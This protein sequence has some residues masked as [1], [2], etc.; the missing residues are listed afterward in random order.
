M[1]STRG[2]GFSWLVALTLFA[3]AFFPQTARSA[4]GDVK[5][6]PRWLVIGD[7]YTSGEGIPGTTQ[8]K[9]NT[10]RDCARATGMLTAGIKSDAKA[11]PIV[12]F[13]TV[14]SAR[15]DLALGPPDFVACTGAITDDFQ[16]QLNEAKAG[17]RLTYSERRPDQITSVL[18][19]LAHSEPRWDLVTMS[20]GG[21]NIGFEAIAKGCID[22]V[23]SALPGSIYWNNAW[24]G[25][26]DQPLEELKNR[27]DILVGRTPGQLKAGARTLWSTNGDPGLYNEIADVVRPGGHVIV[28]GYPH[29]LEDPYRLTADGLNSW[30]KS[31]I[32]RQA[33]N[34]QG[35]K[36]DD[37]IMLRSLTA[38]LNSGIEEA[39]SKAN[40]RY[41][42]KGVTFQ[43][44]NIANEVY[45][46]PKGRHAQCTGEPW[47]NGLTTSL[48]SADWRTQ[49]SFHPNQRGHTATGEFIGKIVGALDF[50]GSPV[51][52]GDGVSFYSPTFNIGCIVD[53]SSAACGIHRRKWTLRPPSPPVGIPPR[54][55]ADEPNYAVVSL[56][57]TGIS[58]ELV[59]G[60]YGAAPVVHYGSSV[61]FGE[62]RCSVQQDGVSCSNGI[63]GFHLSEEALRS[64]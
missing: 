10:N 6:S 60:N 59:A 5:H 12:A 20:L 52:D 42:S 48:S 24:W 34:C 7:S 47:V 36:H 44:V 31:A 14:V 23:T 26:C 18:D 16:Q 57:A 15:Q 19:G 22:Q 40:D 41:A 9:S 53:S 13:E 49:R 55:G 61:Q 64:F 28:S 27:V 29:A 11:W 8:E 25:G 37:I 63:H 1:P 30:M 50:S 45:E 2:L 46:T 38:Y 33:N 32:L 3:S 17:R 58:T 51:D 56:T 54:S 4:E 39:V 21:N 35:V 62:F 43:F